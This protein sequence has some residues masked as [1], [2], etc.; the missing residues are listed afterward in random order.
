MQRNILVCI[1]TLFLIYFD[2]ILLNVTMVRTIP[3]QFVRKCMLFSSCAT[4]RKRRRIIYSNIH[5]F[6]YLLVLF[7][8]MATRRKTRSVTALEEL[9]RENE[10]D[11]VTETSSDTFC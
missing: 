6:I 11:S 7:A 3:A 2:N 8:K 4:L 10:D 9:Y 1:T 5:C